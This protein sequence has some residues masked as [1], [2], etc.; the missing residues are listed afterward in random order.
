VL[1]MQSNPLKTESCIVY[2]MLHIT[3]ELK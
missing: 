3:T 1:A 2:C